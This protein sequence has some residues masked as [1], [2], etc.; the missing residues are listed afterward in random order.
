MKGKERLLNEILRPLTAE[1]KAACTGFKESNCCGAHIEPEIGICG[2]G[3]APWSPET[4]TQTGEG[5][6]EHATNECSECEENDC[7]NRLTIG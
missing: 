1:E 3:F 4:P 2:M 5:C 6:G 7:P